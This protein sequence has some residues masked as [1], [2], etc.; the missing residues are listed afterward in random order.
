[1]GCSTKFATVIVTA[2]AG[3]SG[4]SGADVTVIEPHRTALNE[5]VSNGWLIRLLSGN[6]MQQCAP[7]GRHARWAHVPRKA[8]PGLHPVWAPIR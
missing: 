7:H 6:S 5:T 8:C 4:A 2:V 3:V 1:L